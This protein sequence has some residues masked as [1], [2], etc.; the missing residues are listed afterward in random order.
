MR[1]PSNG[2]DS[3]WGAAEEEGV[4]VG[5]ATEGAGAATGF[6]G[7]PAEAEDAAIGVEDAAIGVEDAA[8]GVEDAAIGVEGAA[9]DEDEMAKGAEG[10]PTGAG[11]SVPSG[12]TA[13]F[14]ENGSRAAAARP[15]RSTSTKRRIETLRI[16]GLATL[17]KRLSEAA[18]QS[19]AG[20]PILS[21]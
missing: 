6:A 4:E 20:R 13:A 16:E 12:P 7:T 19:S 18:L 21:T 5:A 1:L 14:S 11:K 3:G 10:P 15:N 2:R 9:M 8:I 17:R